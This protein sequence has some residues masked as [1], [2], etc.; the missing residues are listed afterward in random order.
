MD[1]IDGNAAAGTARDRRD[2]VRLVAAVGDDV[3]ELELAGDH[4]RGDH[5]GVRAAESALYGR[6]RSDDRTQSGIRAPQ[7]DPLDVAL[8]LTPAFD[9][10]H[11]VHVEDEPDE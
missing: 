5:E 1:T 2:V 7:D 3:V 11:H 10:I 9:T 8:Q 4:V 6:N